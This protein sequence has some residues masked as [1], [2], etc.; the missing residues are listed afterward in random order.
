M[1]Q[2]KNLPAVLMTIDIMRDMDWKISDEQLLIGL[3]NTKRMTGLQG[4]W[5]ILGYNPLTVADTAHNADGIA[6]V[7]YQLTRTPYEK[8]HF[9]LGVVNDKDLSSILSL[10]PDTADY[11][12]AKA[13]IPR[14]LDEKELAQAAERFNLKGSVY[15][16]VEKAFN[17][18]RS[19]AGINDMVFVGGST[20]V[21]AEI[22]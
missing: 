13:D 21:V 16:S 18:A 20:F 1:Y 9:V 12:F 7:V 2:Q 19:R 22:L 17:V 6:E 10:L 11:Y 5:Q 4:R 3:A 15:S 8:L 14:A